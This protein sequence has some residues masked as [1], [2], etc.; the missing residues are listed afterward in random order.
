MLP[1]LEYEFV[2]PSE[3]FWCPVTSEVLLD[4][5]QTRCCGTILSAKATKI[6]GERGACRF[7]KST[8]FETYPDKHFCRRIN[9][10]QV[11]CCNKDRGC[12]WVGELSAVRSHEETCP[13][14]NRPKK[15]DIPQ[16]SQAQ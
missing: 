4:P 7:C 3:E 5:H 13:S 16:L 9:E 8:P 6:L 10:Q 14:K 15:V 2:T 1:D 11:F 12:Q